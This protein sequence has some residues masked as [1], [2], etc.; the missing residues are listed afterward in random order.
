MLLTPGSYCHEGDPGDDG[1]L[2]ER[3]L[4]VRLG[5][6][7]YM[8][9]IG[10]PDGCAISGSEWRRGMAAKADLFHRVREVNANLSTFSEYTI[11]F[12]KLFAEQWD[13][14]KEYVEPDFPFLGGHAGGVN[15]G[16]DGR[17]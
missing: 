16:V 7:D 10:V 11:E 4:M 17:S 8:F 13:C 3:V 14:S 2:R 1:Y 15:G 12:A 9:G 6:L 5:D